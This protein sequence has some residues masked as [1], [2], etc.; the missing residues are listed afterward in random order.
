LINNFTEASEKANEERKEKEEK[1]KKKEEEED[2]N[3]GK[4]LIKNVTKFDK[5]RNFTI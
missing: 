2:K 5:S 4:F 1:S 3:K